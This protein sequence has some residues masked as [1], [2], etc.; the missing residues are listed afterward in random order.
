[1]G[2][3]YSLACMNLVFLNSFH[4]SYSSKSTGSKAITGR[5]LLSLLGSQSNSVTSLNVSADVYIIQG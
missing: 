5:G 4:D 3:P 1:M 2:N